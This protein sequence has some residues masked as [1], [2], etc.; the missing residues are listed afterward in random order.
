MGNSHVTTSW[1][2]ILILRLVVVTP[3]LISSNDV[4][5]KTVALYILCDNGLAKVVTKIRRSLYHQSQ[6]SDPLNF[7]LFLST[8]QL[9]FY[10]LQPLSVFTN[11]F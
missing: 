3:H 10:L 11:Y 7:Y 4:I 8:I 1:T 6:G 2:A 5:Q 9:N